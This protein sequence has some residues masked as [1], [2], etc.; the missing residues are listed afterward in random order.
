[1][2][3]PMRDSVSVEPKV[4]APRSTNS[5]TTSNAMIRIWPNF[6]A[7]TMPLSTGLS[8][9]ATPV[10]ETEIRASSSALSA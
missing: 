7:E 1:M 9:A 6:S 8:I 10:L 4:A 5:A 2:R 3:L